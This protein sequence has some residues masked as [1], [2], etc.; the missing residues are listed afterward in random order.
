LDQDAWREI[1]ASY[2]LAFT[3]G[4]LKQSFEGGGFDINNERRPFR[5]VDQANELSQIDG[6]VQARGGFGEDFS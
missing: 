6:I 1:L 3:R 5:L 4:F 2:L